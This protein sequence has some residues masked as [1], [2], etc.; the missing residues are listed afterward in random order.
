MLSRKSSLQAIIIVLDYTTQRRPNGEIIHNLDYFR[1]YTKYQWDSTDIGVILRF[2]MP[3]FTSLKICN[4][5][6]DT[7]RSYGAEVSNVALFVRGLYM[8]SESRSEYKSP[9]REGYE[10]STY[11]MHTAGNGDLLHMDAGTMV[12]GWTTVPEC[13]ESDP[14]TGPTIRLPNLD[15]LIVGTKVL[16][17]LDAPRLRRLAVAT[18]RF[19]ADRNLRKSREGEGTHLEFAQ[20]LISLGKSLRVLDIRLLNLKA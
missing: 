3:R 15:T 10:P 18:P 8:A 14:V 6:R 19:V 16:L 12:R 11:K 1:Y 7:G 4:A 2:L 20:A 9:Y 13:N 5:T 17:R